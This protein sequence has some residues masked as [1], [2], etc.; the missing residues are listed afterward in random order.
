M[1]VGGADQRL[2]SQVHEIVGRIN[3]RYGSVTFVPSITWQV[4]ELPLSFLFVHIQIASLYFLRCVKRSELCDYH[5]QEVALKQLYIYQL[6]IHCYDGN[7]MNF[8]YLA[9]VDLNRAMHC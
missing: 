4:P 7:W 5:T 9:F 8:L 6:Y 2:T 1:N 3:G